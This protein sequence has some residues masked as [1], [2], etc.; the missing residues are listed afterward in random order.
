MTLFWFLRWV[1]CYNQVTSTF[2]ST[3]GFTTFSKTRPRC[4][5]FSLHFSRILDENESESSPISLEPRSVSAVS[6]SSDKSDKN[7]SFSARRRT[8]STDS[9]VTSD[10]S[11]LPKSA[12]NKSKKKEKKKWYPKT[13]ETRRKWRLSRIQGILLLKISNWFWIN[14]NSTNVNLRCTGSGNTHHAFILR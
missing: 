14:C 5:H 12:K 9:A 13:V 11:K 8:S 1:F 4:F 6:F 2:T 10:S 3:F 7:V